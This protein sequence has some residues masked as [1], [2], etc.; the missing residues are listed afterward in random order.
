[1]TF[2]MA[3]VRGT[4]TALS[5]L[6]HAGNLKSGSTILLNRETWI[7]DDETMDIP[8]VSGNAVRGYLR[9]LAMSDMIERT[10]YNI[11][12][13]DVKGRKLYHA[14]FTGGMLEQVGEKDRGV[15]NLE[16]KKLVYDTIPLARIFGWAHGNQMIE[17]VLKCSR[18]LPICL[19][20]KDYLPDDINPKLSVGN[21]ISE[22]F[23]TRRDDLRGE[24]GK[25]EGATQMLIDYES[26]AAGTKFH[27][28]FRLED[29]TEMDRDALAHI[30][31]L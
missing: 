7:V 19:E 9:R 15:M 27:H 26:F 12:V 22:G 30:I 5:P 11:D 20:L 18:M 31:T 4:L 28:E 14:L 3:I 24:R 16:M 23:Q 13:N 8:F 1:M 2:G 10:G 25:D 17:S 21:L 6:V 29:P